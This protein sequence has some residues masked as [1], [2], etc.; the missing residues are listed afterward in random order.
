MRSLR[1]ALTLLLALGLS[2]CASASGGS[3]STTPTPRAERP[4]YS[5]GD[6]WIRDGGSYEMVR[7][8]NDRYVFAA[9]PSREI[10]LTR[11]LGFGRA[12]GGPQFWEFAP[13][14]DLS[15]PL[16]VGKS[17]STHATWRYTENPVGER[18]RVSWNVDAYEDV[19]VVAGTFKAFKISFEVVPDR[20]PWRGEFTLWYA[21]EVRQF[22]KGTNR[23][24][25][26]INFQVLLI[27]RP[28]EPLAVVLAGLKDQ[29]RVAAADLQVTGKVT[30]GSL[31]QRVTATLNG[32]QV[33]G[34]EPTLQQNEVRLDFPVRLREG[35]NVLIVT[36]VDSG[37]GT[38]QEA[39]TVFYEKPAPAGPAPPVTPPPGPS[40]PQVV[41]K[42]APTPS[43]VAPPPPPV[44]AKPAP[45]PPPV[46]PPPTPPA[47]VVT[48]A[49]APDWTSLSA[50]GRAI[51][52]TI[53]LPISLGYSKDEVARRIGRSRR[54]VNRCLDELADEL[55]AGRQSSGNR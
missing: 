51:L 32:D 46:T 47:T 37:G 39:R 34:L 30:T 31:V 27:D 17:G 40:P 21:P 45:P 50:R 29:D 15:W 12:Q 54:Y 11:N 42:P 35:K 33:K 8:E 41:V 18:V 6:K 26:P 4:T 49:S 48:G 44:V 14:P 24:F 25:S 53:A 19:D 28:T 10:Q 52:K 55:Q 16:Q 23:R 2:A 20:S 9:G 5:V 22:V 1:R 36:A 38:A 3:G 13:P 7:I 43:L